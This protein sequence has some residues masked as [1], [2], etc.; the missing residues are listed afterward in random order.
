VRTLRNAG[1]VA[2]LMVCLALPAHAAIFGTVQG[3]VHDP[4]HRPVP[5]ATVTLR[6]STSDWQQVQVSDAKGTFLFVRV[7][8]G[9]YAITVELQGFSIVRQALTVVSGASPVLHLQ[10]ELASVTQSVT[11]S[12]RPEPAEVG[13]MTP[14][15]LVDRQNIA[16]TPGAMQTN[17]LKAIMS[18]VPGA[19]VT[20]DQLH[21]RGGHQVS[22]LVD[23]VPVP[24]T[25]IAS[26][27]GPQFDPKD[28]DY[29]EV[30]RGS[31]SAE[32]GDRTYGVF[33]VVPRTG[34]ERNREAEIVATAGSY[35]QTDDQVSLGSHT[36]R[37]AYYAS[38]NANRSNLGLETPVP[39]ITHDQQA[40]GGGFG[41]LIFNPTPDNQLRLVASA[42]HD[43]YEIPTTPEEQAAGIA[44]EQ[45]ESDAFVNFSWVRTFEKGILLTVSPFY[46]YNAANYEGGPADPISTVDERAS[47]YVG[48]QATIEVTTGRNQVTGGFYG[49][50]QSDDQRLSVAFNDPPSAAVAARLRP[51]G[52]LETLFVQDRFRPASWL[53]LTAG[54]RQTHF[55]GGVVE[56]ATSPR[57]GGSVQVPKVNWVVRGF[58]GRFYQAPPLATVSGP[59]VEYVTQADLGF[60]PL[61]G[62]R[63]EEYQVGVAIPIHGWTVDVD[64][65][66]TNADNFFDHNPIGNSNV[67]FPLTIEH[68]RIRGVE[69][70]LTSPRIWRS[71]QAHVAYSYQHADGRGAVSGGLTDFEPPENEGYFPLDHDQR[72]TLSAGFSATVPHGFLVGGTL[73]YGSGFPDDDTGGYLAGRATADASVGRALTPVLFVGLNVLNL[74]NNHVLIDNSLTFGGT[75]YNNPREVYVEVRYRFH[76]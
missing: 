20:H 28:I 43:R 36:E 76:Y 1:V 23:G 4:Q 69:A 58:Y 44:A 67:F 72:H 25:N 6:S 37:F 33:N 24:N 29:L 14:T 74:T 70:A 15:T 3:V 35:Y 32:Y 16:Q 38:A 9:D 68:A 13:S 34:F 49:F 8:V 52:H 64:R 41:T 60:L 18:F 53:T 40:G 63:D 57:V 55:S 51:S 47:R 21:L 71:V 56:N 39:E 12:A 5:G 66:Q 22:W 65:F 26:N 45:H 31:Y 19:Y 42:R 59:L 27:V 50:R 10:L 73:Y 30:Q 54:V 62:E 75:H 61:H 2:G 11:V 17:S 46:H 48:A 7:P